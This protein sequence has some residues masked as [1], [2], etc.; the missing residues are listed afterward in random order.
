LSGVADF[1]GKTFA[2]LPVVNFARRGADNAGR[3]VAWELCLDNYDEHHMSREIGD[4]EFAEL[5][6]RF[7]DTVPPAS[8][9]ALVVSGWGFAWEH[10]PPVDL[11]CAA[12]DR[13]TGLKALHLRETYLCYQR[14]PTDPEPLLAAYPRLE[15]LSLCGVPGVKR[16]GPGR[17]QPEH[18]R[19][20]LRHAALRRL[21]LKTAGLPSQVVRAVSGS[22]LPALEHLELWLGVRAEYGGTTTVT[23]LAPILA[24]T[25]WPRLR[26][27][28]LR[29][30][31]HADEVAAAVAAA[32]VTARLSMLDMSL[33]TLGDAG[34]EALLNGQPL[35][36]LDAL[37]LHHHFLSEATRSRL[38]EALADRVNL[39]EWQDASREGSRYTRVRREE[40]AVR[41][42]W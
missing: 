3:P 11:L 4:R 22:E 6:E 34:A 30:A 5:L 40:I 32:P 1:D 12:A 15:D 41:P 37:D 10:R 24:D 20:P 36:H 31:E 21:T 18:W 14:N 2:G 28:G 7:L 33:G 23:D 29:N 19:R 27:L 35:T 25:R 26:Y 9:Q 17:H 38:R 8:V 39:D 13:L 42:T 16:A